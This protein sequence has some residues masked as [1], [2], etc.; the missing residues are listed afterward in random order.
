M[1][2]IFEYFEAN[3]NNVA[4]LW[5]GMAFLSLAEDDDDVDE[6]DVEEEVAA[7]GL[8]SEVLPVEVVVVS[9]EE[10]LIKDTNSP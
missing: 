4:F 7:A 2:L 1:A 8:P 5:I 10:L 3:F 6:D 9:Y